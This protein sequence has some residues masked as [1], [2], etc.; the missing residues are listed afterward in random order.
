M[1]YFKKYIALLFLILSINDAMGQDTLNSAMIE[2]KSYQLYLDKNWSELIAFG[3][4]AVQS[5]F[6][7]YYLQ[8]RI[9]IAY[10]EKKNYSLAEGYFKKALSFNADDELSL[11]YLYYCYLFNGRYE[12]ARLLSKKFN[13]ALADK[14]GTSTQSK[15]GFVML[16]AGSKI[17]DQKTYPS[18]DPKNTKGNYFNPPVYFH[19]GLSH[20]IKNRLPLFHAITYF[21]Q[22]TFVNKVNQY[23]YYLKASIPLKRNFIISPSVHY[24]NLNVSSE[25]K[26]TITDT[27]WPPGV[28]PHSQPPPG[29]PPF[30]TV[31]TSTTVSNSSQS[32]YF[33]GSL[34]IQKTMRKFVFGV[35]MSVSNMSNVTQYINSGFVSYA[36]LG[37][38]KLVLGCSGYAH[39]N[40]SYKTTYAAAVP[41]IYL[42]P[43]HRLSL[44]LSYM[45]NVKNNFIE[46]NGYLV[47]NSPDVTQSRYSALLNFNISKRVSLYGL[48]QLE[49]KYEAIQSF[50]YRYNVIVAGLKITP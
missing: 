20:F 30:K 31:T 3:N 25:K 27:L 33:V 24:I 23:Q 48:Y 28:P 35:G 22:E 41:F 34:S 9:G 14:I 50:N 26:Y 19:V 10:Y 45:Y 40:D 43:A 18:K 11:E 46:E 7:Y 38:S 21:S 42:Q 29:A 16:E 36:P 13:T 4:K 39:T 15:V 17:T 1:S 2:Q 12:E 37:N 6:D 5:G 47:N 49:Y 44:K 8:L 32:N